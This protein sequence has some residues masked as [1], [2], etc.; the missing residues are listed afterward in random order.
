MKT[1]ITM[2]ALAL[3]STPVFAA[4]Q[5]MPNMPGMSHAAAPTE[6]QGVGIVKAIDAARGTITLQHEAIASIRW[7]AACMLRMAERFL[8]DA[9]ASATACQNRKRSLHG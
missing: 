8:A 5:D 1:H 7:I 3:S 9:R 2:L 4:G 6:A